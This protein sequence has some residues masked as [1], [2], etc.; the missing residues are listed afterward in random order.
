MNAPRGHRQVFLGERFLPGLHVTIDAINQCAVQIKQK[1][2]A[3]FLFAAR[4]RITGP[5]RC[6]RFFF[7]LHER[8]ILAIKLGV[9]NSLVQSSQI[10]RPQA[11]TGARSTIQ[12]GIVVALSSLE[13]WMTSHQP[14]TTNAPSTAPRA[15][16]W[17]IARTG[18][19]QPPRKGRRKTH[20][21]RSPGRRAG[22][23][24]RPL[25]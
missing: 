5:L 11:G 12:S 3:A 14:T 1:R 6:V 22:L 18:T 25:L 8:R 7:L 2:H 21:E 13:R 23:E 15:A 4:R 19:T 9:R 10:A 17:D 24:P 16:S 20:P